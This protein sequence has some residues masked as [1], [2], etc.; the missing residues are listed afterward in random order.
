MLALGLLTG[1]QGA[2]ASE[3]NVPPAEN[4]NLLSSTSQTTPFQHSSLK[5][6]Y[7]FYVGPYDYQW[8]CQI[9]ATRARLTTGLARGCVRHDDGKWWY[10]AQAQ[11]R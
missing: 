8:N 3:I 10:I 6:T 11:I 9:G 2:S 7:N 4:Q 1:Q 5:R